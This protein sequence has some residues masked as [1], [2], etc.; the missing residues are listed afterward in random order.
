MVHQFQVVEL[1]ACFKLEGFV[2]DKLVVSHLNY[3]FG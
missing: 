1:T 3:F 2:Y